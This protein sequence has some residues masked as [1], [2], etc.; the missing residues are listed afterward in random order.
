MDII[1]GSC[2]LITIGLDRNDCSIFH[3]WKKAI[4]DPMR[5]KEIPVRNQ[6]SYIT[7]KPLS[8]HPWGMLG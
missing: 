6:T 2:I 7:V 4:V 8:S 1:K 3:S 5:A